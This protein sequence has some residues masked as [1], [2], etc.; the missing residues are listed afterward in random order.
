MHSSQTSSHPISYE[1]AKTLINGDLG[2]VYRNILKDCCAPIY[3]FDR[4]VSNIEILSNGTVTLVQ[5]PDVLIGV[6]AAHVVNAL[7]TDLDTKNLQVQIMNAVINDF[8]SR[9]IDISTKYDLATF[10]LDEGLLS[11]LGKPFQPLQQWP[12][13]PPQEGRGIM[14]AGY[15]GSER[16]EQ[17]NVVDFGL[18]TAL[19]SARTVTEEQITWLIEPEAQVA[20]TKVLPPPPQYGMGGISGGPLITWLESDHYISSYVL[21]GIIIEHPD[22]SSNDFTIERVIAVRADVIMNTGRIHG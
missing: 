15:P 18:F 21:G 3:W 16:N 6:T 17:G 4:D 22:Y 7:L 14:L 9:I 13:K 19:V 5:T 10:H 8:P 20:D 1:A 12:P 11:Q 2:D